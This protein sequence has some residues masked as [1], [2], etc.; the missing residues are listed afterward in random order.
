MGRATVVSE[1]GGGRYL[2]R[3]VYE[4]TQ[5]D[6][7]IQA[8][9]ARIAQI[10]A[11]LPGVEAELNRW[12]AEQDARSQD[13]MAKIQAGATPG[14][15]QQAEDLLAAAE[16][17][18]IELSSRKAALELERA[19]CERKVATLQ[20]YL[21]PPS[22]D[23]VEALCI[24]G[25]TGLTGDVG[26][27]E[28][29]LTDEEQAALPHVLLRPGYGGT[30]AWSG[31]R[32]GILKPP[33][34]CL[35]EEAF[36]NYAIL[37]GMAKWRPRYRL[38]TVHSVDTQSMTLT[39][40]VDG[41]RLTHQDLQCRYA[42]RVTATAEY[43]GSTSVDVFEPGDRVVLEARPPQGAETWPDGPWVVIGFADEPKNVSA[44]LQIVGPEVL[45]DGAQY[46]AIGGSGDYTWFDPSIAAGAWYLEPGVGI[47]AQ[48]IH[49]MQLQVNGD[50]VTVDW[51]QDG[52][53]QS[54]AEIRVQDNQ[55][56]KQAW[57][58]V[59]LPRVRAVNGR[60]STS[61]SKPA[62][63]GD[64]NLSAEHVL[65]SDLIGAMLEGR[66]VDKRA[67]LWTRYT[68]PGGSSEYVIDQWD[69]DFSLADLA[70]NAA[71]QGD[72]DRARAYIQQAIDTTET[73]IGVW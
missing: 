28:V 30:A 72:F 53:N 18:V 27:I 14:E 71:R 2:V 52:S 5:V 38:G 40:D 3:Q 42:G 29:D 33:A 48:F 1:L 7:R 10:D 12:I 22:P 54:Y 36:Y 44:D 39:V 23:P 62:P 60:R 20:A 59:S 67:T 19:A 24:D 41:L 65:S 32:D 31:A 55:T 63:S 17:K 46:R 66:D 51:P 16:R 64:W 13:L 49:P 4:R 15:I 47:P 50:R 21:P 61:T 8:L 25:T 45:Y 57:V 35:P 70:A 58:N 6:R 26:T 73:N 11:N 56:G 9:Q 43:Q 37:P 69:V 68:L 34:A